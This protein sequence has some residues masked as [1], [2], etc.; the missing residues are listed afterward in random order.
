[1]NKD[2]KKYVQVALELTPE[3]HKEMFALLTNMECDWISTDINKID[4]DIAMEDKE[5]NELT[6][7]EGADT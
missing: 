3:Q 2:T 4:F 7:K 6:N 1:M 5:D